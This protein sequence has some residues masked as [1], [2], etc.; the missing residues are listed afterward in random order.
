MS[1]PIV[2]SPETAA[3]TKVNYKSPKSEAQCKADS[4]A[5]DARIQDVLPNG[6]EI[7]VPETAIKPAT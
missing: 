7:V 5:A 2:L 3:A 1:I 4:L 6:I